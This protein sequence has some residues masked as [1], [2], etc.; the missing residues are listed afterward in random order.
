MNL[1]EE[2]STVV[3]I[4]T[5]ILVFM[6]GP[7]INMYDYVLGLMHWEVYFWFIYVSF[8]EVFKRPSLPSASHLT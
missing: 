1:L 5:T 8:Y 2:I 4:N 3:I 6:V 7:F